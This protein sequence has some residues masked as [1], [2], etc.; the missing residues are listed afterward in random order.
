MALELYAPSDG[1][2]PLAFPPSASRELFELRY[3]LGGSG[4]L[5]RT[6]PQP[7]PPEEL[8]P[9]DTVLCRHGAVRL[10]SSGGAAAGAGAGAQL[11]WPGLPWALACL[12]VAMPRSLLEGEPKEEGSRQHGSVAAEAQPALAQLVQERWLGGQPRGALSPGGVKSLLLGAHDTARRALHS[13]PAAE[14]P[15]VEGDRAVL[16]ARQAKQQQPVLSPQQLEPAAVSSAGAGPDSEDV[17][18]RSLPDLPAFELPNQTNRLAVAFCP[19]SSPRGT[20]TPPNFIAGVELFF[21]LGGAGTG[22]CGPPGRQARFPVAPGDVAVF[23]P[24]AVHGI[25][26]GPDS[27]LVCLELMCPNDLFAELVRAGR[28]TGLEDD[29]L[30]ILT[31]SVG[32]PPA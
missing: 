27:K 28:R 30:C 6:S 17:T 29:E 21:I 20:G 31:A 11:L 15:R 12:V 8:Q 23:R 9:G 26:N 3:V 24:G 4:C 10:A 16:G 5:Q 1:Q 22:F 32:C 25:D 2:P 19:Y 18:K 14:Q 7:P 13:R